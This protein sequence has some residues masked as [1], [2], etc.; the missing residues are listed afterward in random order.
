M[1]NV[2]IEVPDVITQDHLGPIEHGLNIFNDEMTNSSDR[3]RL[4]SSSQ[5]GSRSTFFNASYVY[6]HD[7]AK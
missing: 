4:S 5:R 6:K 2:Q 1:L 7:W 3:K